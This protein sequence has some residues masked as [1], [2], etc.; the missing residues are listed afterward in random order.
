M[1]KCPKCSPPPETKEEPPRMKKCPF[2]DEKIR[3]DAV[4]CKHCGEWL[5]QES[6]E[7]EHNFNSNAGWMTLSLC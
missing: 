2:C 1:K 6:T 3:E 5:E 4:K 7:C